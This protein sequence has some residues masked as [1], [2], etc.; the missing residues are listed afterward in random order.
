MDEKRRG[1]WRDGYIY[2][3]FGSRFWSAVGDVYMAFFFFSFMNNLLRILADSLSLLSCFGLVSPATISPA[4]WFP[5]KAKDNGA[6][7]ELILVAMR[8]R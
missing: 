1:G 4:C 6:I 2:P 7:I 5:R 3:S 8:L